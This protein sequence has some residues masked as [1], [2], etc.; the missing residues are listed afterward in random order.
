[1]T[2]MD[3]EGECQSS[4]QSEIFEGNSLSTSV[5][6]CNSGDLKELIVGGNPADESGEEDYYWSMDEEPHASRRR[7]ILSKYPEIKDLNGPDSKLKFTIFGLVLLQIFMCYVSHSLSTWQYAVAAYAIGGTANHML[8]LGMHELAHNLGFKS[9]LN[10]RLL[11]LVANLPL[12]V[13]SCATFRKY[14]LEHHRYQG[15][16]G[17]DVDIPT[18]FESQFLK[19]KVRKAFFVFFQV[20][21][22]ALRPVLVYPKP[23]GFWEITNWIT[24]ISFDLLVLYFGGLK[25]LGYLLLGSLLGTGFHPVAGHFISEHYVFD[26][27]RTPLKGGGVPETYSYYGFWNVFAFNVGYHNEHHDFPY[28]PGSRLPEVRRIAAEY[29]DSFPQCDSWT[30]AL[31]NFITRDDIGGYSRV[32]RHPKKIFEPATKKLD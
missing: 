27:D 26:K 24:S 8:M 28:V 23:L 7:E 9:P 3:G 32:K 16:D 5:S 14:H 21:F 10:N 2:K 19:G 11:A 22:Y 15:W 25:R 30:G 17:I 1:M 31:W 6:S 20:A 12:G 29:Y 18:P 4:E 13:P